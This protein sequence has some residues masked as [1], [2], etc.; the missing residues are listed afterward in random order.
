MF[1]EVTN[2]EKGHQ[3]ILINTDTILRIIVDSDGIVRIDWPY[4]S[5]WLVESFEQVRAMIGQGH[6]ILASSELTVA[7]DLASTLRDILEEL[8]NFSDEHDGK[9]A[10]RP[11]LQYRA[12]QVLK[13][14][15]LR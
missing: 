13:K 7:P 15:G 9:F 11:E 8:N 4:A 2:R 12:E 10:I 1:I 14:A 5:I 6:H 3:P